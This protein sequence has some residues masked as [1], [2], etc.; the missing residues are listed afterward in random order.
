MK[1]LII[2][3]LAFALSAC[4]SF[5]LYSVENVNVINTDSIEIN[6]S[7]INS[8]NR[9]TNYYFH[10]SIEN[11]TDK[12]LFFDSADL[13]LIDAGSGTSHYSISRDL[14]ELKLTNYDLNI[15]TATKLKPN[16]KIEGYILFPT[17]YDKARAEKLN[18]LYMGK[19]LSLSR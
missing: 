13:E 6:F 3:V 1:I 12:E 2:T 4:S 14:S 10:L 8:G 17:A 9:Y 16:R 15:I 5:H 7:R 19:S 11:K 18:L